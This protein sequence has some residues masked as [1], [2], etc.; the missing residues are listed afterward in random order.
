MRA[1]QCFESFYQ[2]SRVR[3]WLPSIQLS[4][5]KIHNN[6]QTIFHVVLVPSIALTNC[7]TWTRFVMHTISAWLLLSLSLLL[8]L[9]LLFILLSFW[10]WV[11][12]RKHWHLSMFRFMECIHAQQQWRAFPFYSAIYRTRHSSFDNMFAAVLLFYYY[13]IVTNVCCCA[14]TLVLSHSLW[15]YTFHPWVRA[16]VFFF[17][18]LLKRMVTDVVPWC[19]CKNIDGKSVTQLTIQQ[20][21]K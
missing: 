9:L 21:I 14:F 11:A 17:N 19:G 18:S 15:F 13:C 20:T 7:S 10:C 3:K 5:H 6:L 4:I 12:Q 16:C 8:L 2:S 1:C